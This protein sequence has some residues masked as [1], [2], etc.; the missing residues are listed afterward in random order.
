MAAMT[1][2]ERERMRE[3]KAAI[4]DLEGRVQAM[5]VNAVRQDEKLDG[6]A[7]KVGT[8]FLDLK[9]VIV[10]QRAE[11][12]ARE[13]RRHELKVQ[14]QSDRKALIM[15]VLTLVGGLITVLGGGAGAVYSMSAD[16]AEKPLVSAEP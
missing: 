16:G 14:S 1:D 9:E 10:A 5:E 13:D 15:K 12:A 4:K 2:D 7:E 11:I 3:N 6:L 8:G